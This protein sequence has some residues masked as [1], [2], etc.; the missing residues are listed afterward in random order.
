MFGAGPRKP[1]RRGL[2]NRWRS[3]FALT[4]IDLRHQRIKI[5]V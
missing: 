2:L 3:T 4:R 1:S 5:I